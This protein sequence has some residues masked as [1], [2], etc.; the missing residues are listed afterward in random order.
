MGEQVSVDETQQIRQLLTFS[1]S[2]VRLSAKARLTDYGHRCPSLP[3]L[4]RLLAAP[5]LT[6]E[7]HSK[8]VLSIP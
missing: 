2:K 4:P 1:A 3:F 7:A 6:V 8:A 5:K